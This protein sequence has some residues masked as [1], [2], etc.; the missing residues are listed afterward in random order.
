MIARAIA[1]RCFWPP[2]SLPPRMPTSVVYPSPRSVVMKSCA[3]A[4]LAASSISACVAPG[5]PYAMFC[6]TLPLKSTGSC[7]TRPSCE[8]SQRTLSVLMSTPSSLTVPSR[9][10]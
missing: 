4:I 9:G 10:S 6:A 5:L 8:R 3:F 7:A 1:T 2:D